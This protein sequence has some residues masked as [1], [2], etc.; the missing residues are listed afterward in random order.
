MRALCMGGSGTAAAP[1]TFAL[2]AVLTTEAS[3]HVAFLHDR[4]PVMLAR[5]GDCDAWLASRLDPKALGRLSAP[6]A[7]PR[8]AWHRVTTQLNKQGELEGPQ[9]VSP[10]KSKNKTVAAMFAAHAR[11][12]GAAGEASPVATLRGEAGEAVKE[13]GGVRD[14]GGAV[15]EEEGVREAGKAVKGE[16]GQS[17]VLDVGGGERGMQKD[18]GG[19]AGRGQTEDDDDVV[20]VVSGPGA[21]GSGAT[22]RGRGDEGAEGGGSPGPLA[23]RARGQG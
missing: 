7:A 20:V 17:G 3:K 5:P 10:L 4:M 1:G 23:K 11:K 18:E 2:R 19:V 22:R 16:G 9:C 13:E 12:G 15:K 14:V 21:R 8:L 6:E